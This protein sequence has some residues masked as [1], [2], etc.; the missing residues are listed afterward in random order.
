MDL[1]TSYGTMLLF[2][3]SDTRFT[4]DLVYILDFIY[5]GILALGLFFTLFWKKRAIW[6]AH[7]TLILITFYTGLCAINHSRALSA[8]HKFAKSHNI[9]AIEVASLPQPFS[10]FLWAN[11]IET[12]QLV[13]QGF[14]DLL[15]NDNHVHSD[16]FIGR[17]KSKF[18]VLN[19]ITYKSYAKF[20]DSLLVEKILELEGVKLFLWFARFPIVLSD[21]IKDDIHILR[22]FDLRFSSIKGRYPFVYEIIYDH[23]GNIK[24]DS[25]KE[26]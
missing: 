19:E 17:Y 11:Y 8:S 26:F 13:Y 22:L 10:P 5:S 6:I 15:S 14:L 20:P 2:P 18:Q 3:F 16:T 25:F 1:Q 9:K 23:K 21:Q 24:S 12:D 4:L 7:L